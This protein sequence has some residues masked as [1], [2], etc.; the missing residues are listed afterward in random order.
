[1][2]FQHYNFIDYDNVIAGMPTM[3]YMRSDHNLWEA[4]MAKRDKSSRNTDVDT[5]EE[6][7]ELAVRPNITSPTSVK[8]AEVID[9]HVEVF[10]ADELSV[11][12]SAVVELQAY[13]LSLAPP[14][15]KEPGA[16]VNA[17]VPY[18]SQT[19]TVLN[20]TMGNWEG[21]PDAYT[22]VWAVD[23]VDVSSDGP[24]MN[25]MPED[26]GKVATCVVTAHNSYGSVAAPPSNPVTIS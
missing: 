2:F 13:E 4:V 9:T 6:D 21:E 25:V 22:Y 3:C 14:E 12:N 10:S 23:G 1:M 5:H 26:A 8:L 19:G 18:A 20:C 15:V 16:P 11:L 7:G 17:D 24:D